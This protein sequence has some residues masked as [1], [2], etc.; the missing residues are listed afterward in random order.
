M[1]GVAIGNM[2]IVGVVTG[3]EVCEGIVVGGIIGVEG[4]IIGV[5]GGII[6]VEGGIIGVEGVVLG[7]GGILND[8]ANGVGTLVEPGAA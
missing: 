3:V 4:G 1:L 6:G 5:E 8:D 7:S 2:G